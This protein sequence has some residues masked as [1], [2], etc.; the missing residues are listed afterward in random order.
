MELRLEDTR[1]P[2]PDVS[3]HSG[4]DITSTLRDVG[5]GGRAQDYMV[6]Q[7]GSRV[8]AYQ[9]NTAANLVTVDAV[10]II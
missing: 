5:V 1:K 9:V 3:V 8:E 4:C 10:Q 6:T 2:Q 7:E